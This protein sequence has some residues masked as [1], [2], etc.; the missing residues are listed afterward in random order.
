MK[1]D[2][3]NYQD[4]S[5]LQEFVKD[6]MPDG[7]LDY[8]E[9]LM[10]ASESLWQQ[11]DSGISLQETFFS[12]G[13]SKVSLLTPKFSRT[14]I[15]LCAFALE[16][17]LKGL[18]ISQDPSHISTGVLSKELTKHNLLDLASLAKLTLSDGERKVCE[19]AQEALPYWGRYPIPLRYQGLKP[20]QAATEQYRNDFLGLH[21][22]L[23]EIIYGAIT[24]GWESGTSA[25]I[26]AF[27]D[28]KYGDVIDLKKTLFNP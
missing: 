23:A 16:N 27:K 17:L 18:L 25:K 1:L 15:L 24:N 12:H 13:E 28:K 4:W 10:A 21:K 14:Y 20:E 26:I 2:E 7:W 8:G 11:K 22:R 9:E 3:K 5:Q 19:I 6:A